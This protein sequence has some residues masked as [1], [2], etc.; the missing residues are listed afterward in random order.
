MSAEA[1]PSP[2]GPALANLRRDAIPLWINALSGIVILILLFKTYSALAN[3][4]DG[5]T[6]ANQKVLWELGGRDIAMIAATLMALR[7]QNAGLVGLHDG[8]EHRS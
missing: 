8:D 7:S 2:R 5:G 6:V 3:P 1:P 4:I